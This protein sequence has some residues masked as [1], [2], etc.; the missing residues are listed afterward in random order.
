LTKFFEK[1]SE[2]MTDCFYWIMPLALMN[3]D[4]SELN[5][6]FSL[7]PLVNRYLKKKNKK[8]LLQ[9]GSFKLLRVLILT[10][11]PQVAPV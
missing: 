8:K 4:I 2:I 5:W 1:N 10:P 6:T 7:V 9:K 3:T 11:N